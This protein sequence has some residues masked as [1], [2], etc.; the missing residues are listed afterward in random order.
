MPDPTVSDVVGCLWGMFAGGSDKKEQTKTYMSLFE[1]YDSIHPMGRQWLRDMKR[2]CE[3]DPREAKRRLLRLMKEVN[4][5]T[6][7]PG[8]FL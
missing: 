8:C 1:Y 5:K 3:S 2:L 6:E 4:R 7:L